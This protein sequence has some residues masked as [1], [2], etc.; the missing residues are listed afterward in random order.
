MGDARHHHQGR[1]PGQARRFFSQ[2]RFDGLRGEGR[3]RGQQLQ[4][5]DKLLRAAAGH[6]AD[7]LVA[8]GQ[9]AVG[10]EADGAALLAGDQG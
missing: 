5:V 9:G 3:D 8:A 1:A 10:D 7:G 4:D 2:Q 6:E